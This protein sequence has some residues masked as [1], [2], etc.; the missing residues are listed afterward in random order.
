MA[1]APPLPRAPSENDI[2]GL[3]SAM[4]LEL[5]SAVLAI[6]TMPAADCGRLDAVVVPTGQ[7]EEVRLRHA[8]TLWE[9]SPAMRFL[10]IANGNPAENTYAKL[11]FDYL[12]G[13]GLRRREGVR[14]QAEPAPNT[15]LQADWIAECV[16]TLGLRDLGL[17]VSPYHLPRA[18]L[19]VLQKLRERDIRLPMFP[20]PVPV[21]PH[22][23]VPE[24]GGTAYELWPGEMLRLLRYTANGW[25]APPDVLR[26]YLVWLWTTRSPSV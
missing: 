10:L 19:T 24:T 11:S 6:L 16:A 3:D 12:R 7:G 17:V 25:V 9:S 4:L 21:A 13:L 1:M 2:T 23:P 22:Q 5:S 20:V 14:V 15:G 18:Y 8:I 26:D